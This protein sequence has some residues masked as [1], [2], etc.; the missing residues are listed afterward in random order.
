MPDIYHLTTRAEWEASILS[1]ELSASSLA[2][3]G[4]IHCSSSEEQLLA[5]AQRLYAG[6]GD[7]VALVLDTDK[8]TSPVKREPSRSGE[9]YPHIFGLI[10]IDAVG[11]VHSLMLGGSGGFYLSEAEV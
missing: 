4:F 11:G 8:L 10:N 3:E 1:K 7:M 6:R 5:V 2:E 9:I